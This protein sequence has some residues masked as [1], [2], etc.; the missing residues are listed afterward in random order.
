MKKIIETTQWNSNLNINF[1]RYHKTYLYLMRCC[2]KNSHSKW[3][4]SYL[5]WN[6]CRQFMC[7]G[8]VWNNNCGCCLKIDISLEKPQGKQDKYRNKFTQHLLNLST[9]CLLICKNDLEYYFEI[10]IAN[11]LI[12]SMV[13]VFNVY[14]ANSSISTWLAP[15]LFHCNTK[16]MKY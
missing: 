15:T 3:V 8:F 13:Q 9:V 14:F 6:L 16:I 4:F 10:Q 5:Q 11:I 7:F 1:I 12:Y 2:R